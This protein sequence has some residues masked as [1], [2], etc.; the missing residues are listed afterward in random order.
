[1]VAT[2]VAPGAPICADAPVVA[3][4]APVAAPAPCA[5][6]PAP[7]DRQRSSRPLNGFFSPWNGYG[8]PGP[9]FTSFLVQLICLKRSFAYAFESRPLIGS[10]GGTYGS[11]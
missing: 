5:A 6:A 7:V 3:P 9:M 4:A 8:S 11:P 10:A 2:T 1:M